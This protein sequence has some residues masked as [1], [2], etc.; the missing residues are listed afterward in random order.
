MPPYIRIRLIYQKHAQFAKDNHKYRPEKS[1]FY[2][3]VTEQS[4][5]NSIAPK[6]NS[7]A[8]GRERAWTAA[9][10]DSAMPLWNSFS[11]EMTGFTG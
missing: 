8:T 11:D 10:S 2:V 7:I 1:R 9:G 5:L 6:L 4:H 3:I